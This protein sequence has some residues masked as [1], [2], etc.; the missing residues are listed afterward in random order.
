MTT[1]LQQG[2]I[3]QGIANIAVAANVAV[4]W[5]TTAGQVVV[6]GVGDIPIG[7]T[8]DAYAAGAEVS[9]YRWGQ[10]HEFYISCAGVSAGDYVKCGAAG[11]LVQEGTATVVT[12]A[13]VGQAKTASDS[14]NCILVSASR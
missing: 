14:A 5:H 4:K 1:F 3:G 8:M 2:P 11:A 6:A 9:F 10:G 13:T 12:A 7:V